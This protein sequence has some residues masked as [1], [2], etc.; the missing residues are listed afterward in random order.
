MQFKTMA[1]VEAYHRRQGELRRLHIQANDLC[2]TLCHKL[3]DWNPDPE[4]AARLT[5]V[6]TQARA[7]L[8]R[9]DRL[10]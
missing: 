2:N 8:A 4:R 5:R 1:D 9:R 10:D 7:R 6:L 3:Y